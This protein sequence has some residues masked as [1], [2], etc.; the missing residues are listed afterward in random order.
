MLTSWRSDQ[1][2]RHLLDL[3]IVLQGEILEMTP[4]TSGR[5]CRVVYG[6]PSPQGARVARVGMP[7]RFCSTHIKEQL[8]KG[9][10]PPVEVLWR[11]NGKFALKADAVGI[12]D[13]G[14]GWFI[15]AFRF[16]FTMMAVYFLLL[17]IWSYYRNGQ[18]E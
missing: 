13:S 2:A 14:G 9:I 17:V 1:T 11:D 5:L 15:Y 16:A 10:N 18:E 4:G 7:D 8:K 6:F 3:G 12:V